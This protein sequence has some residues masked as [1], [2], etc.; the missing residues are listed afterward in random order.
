[1]DSTGRTT[2][3]LPVRAIV[4]GG[5]FAAAYAVLTLA[6]APLSYGA[7]QVRVSNLLKPIALLHP[8]FALAIGLGTGM[9]DLFSPFG[10]WDFVAMPIVDILAAMV[11]WKLRCVP[12]LAIFIQSLIVSAG[13]C[14]FPL[15]IAA[16][17]PV[18]A[19]FLPVLI[20][21]VIVPLVGYAVVWRRKDIAEWVKEAQQ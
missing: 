16:R 8:S 15:G 12:V 4:Y 2:S 10:A 9:S 17:I 20:P 18:D 13:V 14:V 6:I 7:F 19:T 21:N 11:C 5:V 1:M 3:V